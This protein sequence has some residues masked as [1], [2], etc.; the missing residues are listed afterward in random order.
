MLA[1]TPGGRTSATRE[2]SF[3]LPN[4]A[5]LTQYI[6]AAPLAGDPPHRH[7]IAVTAVDVESLD[8]DKEATPAVLY[9]TLSGHT[10]ARALLVPIATSAG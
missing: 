9:A 8:L 4:D 10:L 6:G 7:Y 1:S 2:S 5:R 3:Q